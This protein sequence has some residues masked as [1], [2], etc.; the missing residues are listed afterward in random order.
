MIYEVGDLI[1]WEIESDG[2]FPNLDGKTF[3]AK[4][5]FIDEKEQHYGVMSDYGC[6]YIDF[7]KCKKVKYEKDN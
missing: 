4:I 1:E 7:D 6:D 2:M 3:Q 5:C